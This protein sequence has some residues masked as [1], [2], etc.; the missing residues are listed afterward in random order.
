MHGYHYFGE[1]LF[2]CNINADGRICFRGK[3]HPI[4]IIDLDD[5]VSNVYYSEELP[6]GEW[7]YGGE[8]LAI[9]KKG[10]NYRFVRRDNGNRGDDFELPK[11][12]LGDKGIFY[13][14]IAFH[15]NNI[16]A[17]LLK[18]DGGVEFWD[19]KNREW[20]G[21][22]FCKGHKEM[23]WKDYNKDNQ[24]LSFSP[25]GK[26]FVMSLGRKVLVYRTPCEAV[27]VRGTED[28]CI[29]L[30]CA[31]N[32]C[33]TDIHKDVKWNIIN[34]FLWLSKLGNKKAVDKIIDKHKSKIA[35]QD[36]VDQEEMSDK[37][38]NDVS[39]L[40]MLTEGWV[41]GSAILMSAGICVFA[42]SLIV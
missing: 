15:K 37:K 34:A 19:Y 38:A 29:T 26:Q 4:I 32:N 27:C 7:S 10:K 21:T 12:R 18:S 3:K 39:N 2:N 33:S 23:L 25:N 9:N 16:T 6:S 5:E 24:L 17:A 30:L 20:L 36:L 41:L 35:V 13:I 22:M 40:R 42:Y 14:S 11:Q 1:E 8:F 31:L 28:D